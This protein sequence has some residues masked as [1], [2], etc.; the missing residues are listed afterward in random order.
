MILLVVGVMN[1]SEEFLSTVREELLMC[2]S[3]KRLIVKS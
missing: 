3:L 1:L 2:K